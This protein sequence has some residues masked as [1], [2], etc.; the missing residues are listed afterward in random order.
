MFEL[1]VRVVG[2]VVESNAT[3]YRDQILATIK[4]EA[5]LPLV[6]DEDFV[7]TKGRIKEFKEIE[8]KVVLTKE[9]AQRASAGVNELYGVIDEILLSLSTTRLAWDKRVKTEED[10]RKLAI[11]NEA[12]AKARDEVLLVKEKHPALAG[13]DIS[14]DERVIRAATANKKSL[15]GMEKGMAAASAAEIE[16]ILSLYNQ[17]TVNLDRI[18]K[19][20]EEYPGLFHDKNTV[21]LKSNGEV[22]LIIQAREA[23]HKYRMSELQKKKDAEAKIKADAEAAAKAAAD[24]RPAQVPA[25]APAP[26]ETVATPSAPPAS[27]QAPPAKVHYSSGPSVSPW[28][29]PLTAP[30]PAVEEK[31]PYRYTVDLFCTRTRAIEISRAISE[32]LNGDPAVVKGPAISHRIEEDGSGK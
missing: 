8:K 28:T 26:V 14:L 13:V 9:E 3:E 2:E 16:R 15:A 1:I 32:H 21:C 5:D 12:L 24:A 25:A 29:V 10:K 30:R 11:I 27:N 6:T 18:N 17:A 22:L 20:E 31:K 23:D 19:S 7:R 4:A